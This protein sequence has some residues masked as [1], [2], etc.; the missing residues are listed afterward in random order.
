PDEIG[1]IDYVEDGTIAWARRYPADPW[2]AK[3]L[4][5]LV[6]FY[7]RAGAGDT[8]RALAALT[9]LASNFPN[10]REEDLALLA[11]WSTLAVPMQT[12]VTGQVVSD[13]TGSPVSG[14]VVMVA[15]NHESSDLGSTPF[16]TTANDGSFTVANV[17]LAAPE[18]ILVEP[19]LGSAFAVYHGKFDPVAGKAVAGI[20]RLAFR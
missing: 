18:Y 7:A 3:A 19:P 4:S 10:S 1:A 14:A 12:M 16:A 11:R 17:P 13:S 6:T 9:T 15:P 2:L 20:I 5:R 8:P